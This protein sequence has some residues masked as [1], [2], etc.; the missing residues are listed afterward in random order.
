MSG[1]IGDILEQLGL[2]E[3]NGMQKSAS[4][5]DI[6]ADLDSMI[7]SAFGL[8]KKAN[9]TI[10]TKTKAEESAAQ[11]DVNDQVQQ[12]EPELTPE[13]LAELEKQLAEEEQANTGSATEGAKQALKSDIVQAGAAVVQDAMTELLEDQQEKVAA[14]QNLFGKNTAKSILF[15]KLAADTLKGFERIIRDH[16]FAVYQGGLGPTFQIIEDEGVEQ[17][18]IPQ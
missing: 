15:A 16:D 4:K 11:S 7:D 1:T 14:V 17:V 12:T 8:T 10:P 18:N 9:S 3:D 6:Y 5:K 13:E 2:S